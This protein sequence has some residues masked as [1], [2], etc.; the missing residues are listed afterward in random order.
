MIWIGLVSPKSLA[1]T[2]H[3]RFSNPWGPRIRG[4]NSGMW[5]TC[6]GIGAEEIC[7][8][9]S[10]QRMMIGEGCCWNVAE[11]SLNRRWRNF[12]KGS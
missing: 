10:T 9:S 3:S 7:S 1:P 4:I 12:R 11:S 2:S 6:M 8:E 5:K